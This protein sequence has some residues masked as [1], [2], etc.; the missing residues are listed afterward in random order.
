MYFYLTIYQEK[1][2]CAKVYVN[3]NALCHILVFK[4]RHNLSTRTNV[5]FFQKVSLFNSQ[6]EIVYITNSTLYRRNFNLQFHAQILYIHI[7]AKNVS[8]LK[9]LSIWVQSNVI[10]DSF[11][12]K[13]IFTDIYIL[14]QKL[15]HFHSSSNIFSWTNR[16]NACCFWHVMYRISRMT[17]ITTGNMRYVLFIDPPFS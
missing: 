5:T 11:G 4:L 2:F 8:F 17:A 13:E 14:Q 1:I 3:L 12:T 9:F 15:L 10:L 7:Q 16:A 6:R